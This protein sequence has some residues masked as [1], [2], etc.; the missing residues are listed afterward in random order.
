MK[1]TNSKRVRRVAFATLIALILTIFATVG[2]T[3]ALFTDRVDTENHINAGTL[4]IT[5]THTE[6]VGWETDAK[7]QLV[8]I[9]DTLKNTVLNDVEESIFKIENAQPTLW[10]TA[11][12]KVEN[13]DT[14]SFNYSVR[15]VD[16]TTTGGTAIL[17]GS[18]DEALTE[19]L[20]VTISGF[21]HDTGTIVTTGKFQ[22][23]DFASQNANFGELECGQIAEFTVTVEFENIVDPGTDVYEQGATNN[24]AQNGGVMFDIQITAVQSTTADAPNY[25]P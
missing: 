10:Q 23:K 8:Q 25:N 22:L 11:V 21:D 24:K 14:V 5:A 12:V 13:K 4:K 2:V 18:A 15:I 9:T 16:L 19:Q 17:P 6:L 20:W 1:K 3:Y 7:G